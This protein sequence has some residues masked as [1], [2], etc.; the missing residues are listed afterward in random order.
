MHIKNVEGKDQLFLILIES[1]A[2]GKETEIAM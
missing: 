2:R 1:R